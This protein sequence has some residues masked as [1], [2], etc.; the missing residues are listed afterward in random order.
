MLRY[1]KVPNH[2]DN[3]HTAVQSEVIFL[4]LRTGIRGQMDVYEDHMISTCH[5]PSQQKQRQNA[6]V[7]N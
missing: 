2:G 1:I 4:T 7:S 6:H 3:N 5:I